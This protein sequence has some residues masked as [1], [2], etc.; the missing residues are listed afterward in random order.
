MSNNKI[1]KIIIIGAGGFGREILWTL[2]DCNKIIKQYEILGFVDDNMSLKNKKIHDLP[3]LGDID[4]I[5][6][7]VPENVSFIIGIGDSKIRKK[8]FDKLKDKNFEFPV[9]KHPSVYCSDS[10]TIGQ[11]TIIQAGSIISIDI[12]I[13]EFVYVNFNSTIG[14]DSIIH[15]FVTLSPGVNVS[16][17]NLIEEGVFVG[18]G[19]VTKQGISIGKWS[20]IGGGT[21]LGKSIPKNSMF[22]AASGKMKKFSS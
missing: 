16:G 8:I 9:I 5:L 7:S 1:K 18:T 19:S 2:N 3:V 11:G 17:S 15:D 22:Y 6:S 14:H 20:F 12:K 4:W 21:V 13:G 10:I